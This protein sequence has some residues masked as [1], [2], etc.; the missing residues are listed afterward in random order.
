MNKAAF[1]DRDGTINVD[2]NYLYKIEE[3]EYLN[4]AI[5]NLRLLQEKGF[6]LIIITNQSGIARGLF[7]EEEYLRLQKWMVEDL[8]SK[9]ITITA[10][11]YCPHLPTAIIPKYRCVCNCR[12][13]G[14]ELFYKAAKDYNIDLNKSVA[15]GDKTRD[16]CICKVT[17]AKG[18]YLENGWDCISIG[19]VIDEL[20]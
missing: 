18:I 1:L 4:G 14:T 6:L 12:K 11:Y 13:P 16:L 2:K 9:G 17:D 19:E 7:T 20:K 3:F 5:E 10:C 15:I 8:K